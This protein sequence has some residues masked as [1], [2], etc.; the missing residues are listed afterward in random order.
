ME[1]EVKEKV[2]IA[3]LSEEMDAIHAANSLYWQAGKV[4]TLAERAEYQ[5][6]QDRLDKIRSELALLSSAPLPG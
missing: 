1:P 3:A 5:F 4:H 2:R 6:R